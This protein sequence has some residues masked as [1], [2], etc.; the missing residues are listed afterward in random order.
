MP[1]ADIQAG[2]CYHSGL[3]KSSGI[4]HQT[5]DSKINC[6]PGRDLLTDQFFLLSQSIVT[7]FLGADWISTLTALVWRPVAQWPSRPSW[8]PVL[9]KPAIHALQQSFFG[10]QLAACCGCC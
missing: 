3:V 6:P 7:A 10:I 9:P 2:N 5:Q 4:E 1:R 8:Q